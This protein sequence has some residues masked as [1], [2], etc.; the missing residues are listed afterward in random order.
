GFGNWK[1]A[2]ATFTGLIA[3]ENVVGTFGV[4]YGFAEV[5]EDGAEI[6]SSLAADFTHLTAYSFMIFN[7]LCAPCF[8]AMGAI[9]REMNNAKWTWAAIGYMTGFAYIV[10]LIVYQFGK[11][12]SGMGFGFGTFVALVFVV[13]LGYLLFRKNR[14]RDDIVTVKLES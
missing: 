8:A 12:F 1:A 3:K 9:K 5:A 2:V 14:Y 13:G 11:L 10:S 4:L 6:W 7:L